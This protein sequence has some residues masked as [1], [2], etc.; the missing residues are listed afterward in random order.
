MTLCVNHMQGRATG[1]LRTK[2]HATDP[3]GCR[4]GAAAG[5]CDGVILMVPA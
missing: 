4:G 3:A 2:L 1:A 5:D